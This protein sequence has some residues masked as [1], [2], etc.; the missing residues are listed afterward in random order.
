MKT[1][2]IDKYYTAMA[3]LA[4]RFD[5]VARKLRYNAA[6]LKA[7]EA[8]KTSVRSKLGDITGLTRMEA[9]DLQP[10]RLETIQLD[11]YRR[12]KWLIQTEPGVWMPFYT[13][14]P[15]D[16][17]PGEKRS[18][19]IAAHGHGSAGK[20]SRRVEPIYRLLKK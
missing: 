13:L 15:D 8:W 9:C 19:M 18:C 10:E 17:Q 16:L 11:G 3:S 14:I 12:E 2:H 7:H 4:D 20:F 6:D 1:A 5:R